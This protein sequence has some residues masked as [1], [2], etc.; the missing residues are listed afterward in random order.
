LD[1]DYDMRMPGYDYD[2]DYDKVNMPRPEDE[3]KYDFDDLPPVSPPPPSSSYTSPHMSRTHT[4]DL[5]MLEDPQLPPSSPTYS[6]CTSPTPYDSPAI[7]PLKRKCPYDAPGE[8][9]GESKDLRAAKR[10]FGNPVEGRVQV[11]ANGGGD[12]SGVA[13]PPRVVNWDPDCNRNG[14]RTR[15][16]FGATLAPWPSDTGAAFVDHEGSFFHSLDVPNDQDTGIDI[17]SEMHGDEP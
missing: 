17:Q 4:P 5:D 1:Y 2:C 13:N 11:A 16:I 10:P 8:D 14:N 7:S 6:L 12:A 3:Y 15:L 9:E